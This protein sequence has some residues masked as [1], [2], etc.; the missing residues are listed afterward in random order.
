M[1]QKKFP[2]IFTYLASGLMLLATI[3]VT[4]TLVLDDSKVISLQ[5]DK[6]HYYSAKYYSDN[7]LLHEEVLQKGE[8]LTY[9]ETPTKDT[10]ANGTSYF[11]VGWDIT[12]DIIPDTV[13]ERIYSNIKA[14]AIYVPIPKIDFDLSKI[15]GLLK[16]KEENNQGIIEYTMETIDEVKESYQKLQKK[17]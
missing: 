10:D 16:I 12:G 1:N 11:F 7:V 3:L 14:K 15:E 2:A 9:K 17:D 6:I 8:K 4:L 5:T 13:P